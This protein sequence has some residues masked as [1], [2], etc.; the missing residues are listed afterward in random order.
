MFN[1]NPP[2]PQQHHCEGMRT[3]LRQPEAMRHAD[4]SIVLGVAWY[5]AKVLF[6]SIRAYNL[7]R[8]MLVLLS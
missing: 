1:S 7:C 8:R 3:Q 5:K 2:K 4:V 6:H